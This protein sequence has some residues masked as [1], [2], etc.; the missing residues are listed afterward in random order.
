MSRGAH[1]FDLSTS[2][3]DGAVPEVMYKHSVYLRLEL[4]ILTK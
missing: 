3:T 4:G 1:I 2:I